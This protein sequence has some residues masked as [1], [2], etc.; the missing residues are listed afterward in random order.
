MNMRPTLGFY[1][2]EQTLDLPAHSILLPDEVVICGHQMV[3]T[4][5]FLWKPH[6]LS[7]LWWYGVLRSLRILNYWHQPHANELIA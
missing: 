1:A 7:M 2:G 6:G 4:L 5:K 3:Q